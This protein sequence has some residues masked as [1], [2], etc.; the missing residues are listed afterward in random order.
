MNAPKVALIV[1][2]HSDRGRTG[3]RR[4]E[5]ESA[6][7]AA[8]VSFDAVAT[9]GPG[10][11]VDLAR[12][13]A[14]DGYRTVC[15]VGGD[16]TL[17]EVLNGLLDESG[18]A[19]RDVRLATIGRGTGCDWARNLGLGRRL[20]VAIAALG[21]EARRVDVGR[22]RFASD[23]RSEV[24]RY[25]L[26]VADVGLGAFVAERLKAGQGVFPRRLTFLWASLRALVEFPGADLE[27]DL[28]GSGRRARCKFIVVAN[29]RYFGGG[30]KV[31]PNAL[32]DDGLFDVV[33]AEE[34]GL[35]ASLA[36]V[37]RIYSGSHLRLASVSSLRARKVAISG[38][39]EVLLEMEGERPG[40]LP[41]SFEIVPSAISVMVP[42]PSST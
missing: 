36:A 11:A 34:M 41:A 2:P 32:P 30:M 23:D 19:I 10:D 39:P 26:N 13:A 8:K 38:P 31:A 6:L 9:S 17:N 33:I 7:R 40:R 25:F 27:I 4:A 3:A 37:P 1:N 15:S 22:A 35:V 5:I 12:R 18:R 14:H 24:I 21:G 16:G 28:D 29:G 20:D 42:R